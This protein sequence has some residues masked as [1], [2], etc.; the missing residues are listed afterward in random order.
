MTQ[1]LDGSQSASGV[2]RPIPST[3]NPQPSAAAKLVGMSGPYAST[4]S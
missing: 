3:L 4:R 1:R 2:T